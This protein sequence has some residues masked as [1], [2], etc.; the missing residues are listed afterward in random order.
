MMAMVAV[1]VTVDDDHLDKI[2]EVAAEL[3]SNGMQ[4]DQVLNEVGVIS[5]SVPAA[6]RQVLGTVAGIESI[7]EATTFQLPPP[8]SPIQ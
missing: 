2:D 1:K 7:E 4:V 5:G 3:R 6:R 8:D